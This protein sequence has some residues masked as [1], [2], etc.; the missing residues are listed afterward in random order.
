MET[1]YGQGGQEIVLYD[2]ANEWYSTEEM[3]LKSNQRAPAI[4]DHAT[5]AIDGTPGSITFPEL[6]GER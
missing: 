5:E 3:C 4:Y 2:C 1:V 6:V